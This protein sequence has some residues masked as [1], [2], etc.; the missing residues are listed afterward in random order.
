MRV[1]WDQR[2]GAIIGVGLGLVAPQA[3]MSG[4]K[5]IGLALP[6]DWGSTLVMEPASAP[7]KALK[8]RNSIVYGMSPSA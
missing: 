2:L 3:G 4:T 8:T 7:P 5:K 1:R 6:S